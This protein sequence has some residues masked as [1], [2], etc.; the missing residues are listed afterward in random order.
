M[1]IYTLDEI[2]ELLKTTKRT[3][4]KYLKDGKLPASKIGREWRVTEEQLQAFLD[5]TTQGNQKN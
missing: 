2:S 3:L 1:T 4:Y 5:N